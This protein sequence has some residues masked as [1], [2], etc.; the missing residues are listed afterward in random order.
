MTHV[1]FPVRVRFSPKDEQLKKIEHSATFVADLLRSAL[2]H[3]E[4]LTSFSRSPP[5]LKLRDEGK[6]LS[7]SVGVQTPAE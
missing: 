3:R 2:S 6:G 1:E 4:S 5:L 7:D